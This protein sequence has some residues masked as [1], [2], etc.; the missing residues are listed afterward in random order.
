MTL[1][2][3]PVNR[4]GWLQVARGIILLNEKEL[5]K[6]DSIQFGGDRSLN[7]STDMGGEILL[8]DRA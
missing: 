2:M 3:S 8:F 4:Y 1:P 5:R 6:G 7:L